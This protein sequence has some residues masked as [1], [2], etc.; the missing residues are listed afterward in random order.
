MALRITEFA[1]REALM[2]AAAQRL[3]DVLQDAIGKHGSACA[4]LSGG[5]TPAPAYRAFATMPLDWTKIT[6]ALVDERFV[7]PSHAASNEALVRRELGAALDRKSV[8]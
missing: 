2:Q 5:S 7:P 1:T 8:V 3:A 4:A 6:F